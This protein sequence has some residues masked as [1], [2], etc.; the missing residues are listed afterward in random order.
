MGRVTGYVLA[1]NVAC[2]PW[3]ATIGLRALGRPASRRSG[4]RASTHTDTATYSDSSRSR[5]GC[6]LAEVKRSNAIHTPCCNRARGS[7][8]LRAM[9]T[10]NR[11][12]AADYFRFVRTNS[13]SYNALRLLPVAFA[14]ILAAS[15]PG[16]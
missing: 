9:R 7:L 16:K 11:R 10:T 12:V 4:R 13:R 1:L 6:L 2:R 5:A 8:A 14:A 3:Q 15:L